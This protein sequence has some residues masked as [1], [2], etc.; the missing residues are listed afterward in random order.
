MSPLQEVNEVDSSAQAC[1]GASNAKLLILVQNALGISESL[2]SLSKPLC[3]FQY[4][5]SSN[6]SC[7]VAELMGRTSSTPNG[8]LLMPAAK[9]LPFSQ[10]A[11]QCSQ[12][13]EDARKQTSKN[14]PPSHP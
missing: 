10:S 4:E 12:V 14:F 6:V 9:L 5:K 11:A 3:F 2:L 7:V 1:F 13:P 8:P